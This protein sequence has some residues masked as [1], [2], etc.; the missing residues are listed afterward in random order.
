ME[1]LPGEETQQIL[2]SSKPDGTRNLNATPCPSTHFPSL[3]QEE[4]GCWLMT[5]ITISYSPSQST[6]HC[7]IQYSTWSSNSHNCGSGGGRLCRIEALAL[8]LG[9]VLALPLSS[10]LFHR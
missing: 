10:S 9:L 3:L 6:K 7:T 2:V 1:R 5:T 4:S 8:E